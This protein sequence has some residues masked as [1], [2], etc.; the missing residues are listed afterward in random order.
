MAGI[1]FKLQKCFSEENFFSLI[2][3]TFYSVII[4]S[5]PWLISVVTIA[6]VSILAQQNISIDELLEFK[7]II[8]YCYALSLIIFGCIEMPITRYLADQLYKNDFTTFKSLYYTLVIA[9]SLLGITICYYFFSSFSNYSDHY[10]LVGTILFISVLL[11]WVS[12]IFLSAAKKYQ[13]ISLSFILGGS[14]SVIS[15]LCLKTDANALQYL[16]A[17]T[18]G[19][20]FICVC[21]GVF[22]HTEFRS[23]NY[24]SFDFL[25]YFRKH[26]QLIFAGF[27]Y[28]S[29]IWVD[30][31]IFWFGPE[32]DQINGYLYTN[33]YYDTAMFMAYITIVPS[34]AIFMVQVETNFYKY[35]KFYFQSIEKKNNLTLIND[36]VKDIFSSLQRTLLNLIK[37]QLILTCIIWYFSSEII[38]LLYLPSIITPIFRYGIIGAMLQAIILVLNI[39]L[40]YFNDEKSVFKNYALLFFSNAILTYLS[41][42]LDLRYYGIGYLGSTV[43]VFIYSL[44]SLN[45]RLNDINFHTFTSQPIGSS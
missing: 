20:L 23:I 33:K 15:T 1:G 13:Q 27:L 42:F 41:T 26:I 38:S 3:G 40:L 30:K 19:Q 29:S 32:G 22:I 18:L 44:K 31:V 24:V 17:Y 28:Y 36:S 39:V 21:L 14:I 37:I 10:R 11:I 45:I 9:A 12:M 4:S 8:C 25:L 6:L 5:G 35:Y 43:I 2:K 34:L 7:A 16:Q